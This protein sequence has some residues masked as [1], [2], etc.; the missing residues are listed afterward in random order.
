MERL[1]QQVR[2]THTHYCCTDSSKLQNP[3]RKQSVS[4]SLK[5]LFNSSN[6]F[7]KTLKRGVYLAVVLHHKDSL[8]VTAED[9][10]PIV[11]VDDSY[12]SSLMQDFLWFTKLSCMWEDVRWLRQ[13]MSVS[14]SSSSTLQARH[15][16]LT[17]AGQMQVL[18]GTHNLGRVHYEPIKDRHGNVLLV[19]TREAD[20]T[21]T[22]TLGGGKWMPV[23][24]LQSQ[25]KSLSTPEEPYALD[26]LIIT[27]QD[28]M[29]YQRRGALRLSPGLYLGFLKLSSSV[30]QIRVL[31][32]QRHPNMLCHT[33]VRDNG[34]V[35][36]EEWEW[37]QALATT[38]ERGEEA[39]HQ[40]ESHAPLLYYELQTSIKALLKHLNLPLH[41][42]RLLRLYSQ[43]VVELGHG[44]SF[45]L[46]LPAADD[47]FELVHFCTYKEKFIGLYCRLSSVLDLDALITQQA[48]REAISDSEV[49]S[50][51]QRHQLILD[52][53]QQ[54]DEVRRDLRWIT[55]ALQ[56]ARYRQ[57]R[58][59][60]PVSAL[61]NADAPPDSEQK[62]DSTSS[63]NDF[64][65]TPSPS[66]E[67]RR[68]KPPSDSLL[69]SDEDGSSEVFLPTDSD[70]DS[71]DAV[72]PRDLDLLYSPP[73]TPLPAGT[74]L[75]GRQRPRRAADPRAQV[76][77][78][79][80]G[81]ERTSPLGG[82]GG[83]RGE[84][85]GLSLSP[86]GCTPSRRISPPPSTPP[87]SLA[88]PPAF[89]RAGGGGS[90]GE[91]RGEEGPMLDA[92][93]WGG[94]QW[95][96]LWWWRGGEEEEGGVQEVD[97]DEQT[98]AQVSEILSS[99]L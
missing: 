94:R 44:V 13:S 55:D 58:G 69:G 5:H 31:V 11:E 68:R 52:Y 95:G 73:P 39:E 59:G 81:E 43:E 71:S 87:P 62:T 9:Q 12:S 45:L 80:G 85:G 53:I 90:G 33:R 63:N 25:R 79:G 92:S 65:P 30:D 40:L 15:K 77:L 83:M 42:S 38:G 64:L 19:T 34:N 61:V 20:S 10:I 78:S 60:V 50:A 8:L 24:K 98:N 54:L 56:F 36:R 76:Q 32:S 48:L 67:P 22:N 16:M 6:K 26:I 84:R 4:R 75:A 96:C 14:T 46:L 51:K 35:S 7:V 28:I 29:A 18:L 41:Q 57:P 70:Y 37:M 88:T 3:S 89:W 99:S 17:A 82:S 93:L 49:S 97:S 86:R 1:L 47:M 66:P 23:S 72:S 27:I 91:E 21:H 2:A 74:A